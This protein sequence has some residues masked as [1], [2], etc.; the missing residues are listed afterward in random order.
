MHVSIIIIK[1]IRL[2]LYLDFVAYIYILFLLP[3]F[4]PVLAVGVAVIL[5]ISVHDLLYI[6]SSR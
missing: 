3:R 4:T 5:G 2:L 6:Y 1:L